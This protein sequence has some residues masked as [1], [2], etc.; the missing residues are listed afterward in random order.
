MAQATYRQKINGK[1]YEV[2]DELPEYGSLTFTS[3]EE[4]IV[5]IE[6]LSVDVDK[7]PTWV[8]QGSQAYMIDTERLYK[9]DGTNKRWLEQ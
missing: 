1:V 9:F 4:G 2:G 5:S 6:G 3:N 7:L 8:R